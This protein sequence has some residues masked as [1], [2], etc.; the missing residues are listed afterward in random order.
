MTKHPGF[1]GASPSCLAPSCPLEPP[2]APRVCPSLNCSLEFKRGG[3]EAKKRGPQRQGSASHGG[4]DWL[5]CRGLGTLRGQGALV[6]RPRTPVGPDGTWHHTPASRRV[7]ERNAT[8]AG[9]RASLAATRAACGATRSCQGPLSVRAR[10]S[11]APRPGP[12]GG[13]VYSPFHFLLKKLPLWGSRWEFCQEQVAA[14]R[15]LCGVQ[16]AH[17]AAAWEG[18]RPE[19]PKA[20]PVAQEARPLE[21][22]HF[23][24]LSQNSTAAPPPTSPPAL[25]PLP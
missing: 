1:K 20:R 14:S 2:P 23:P 16:N 17:R 6:P 25:Q 9:E 11:P 21:N 12:R 13:L 18:W 10:R 4:P 3:S 7:T 24:G 19:A 8:A 22:S 5:R 15:T